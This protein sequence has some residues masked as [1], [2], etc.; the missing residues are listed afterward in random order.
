VQHGRGTVQ[1]S[2]G[3]G[4]SILFG[5]TG[6][7]LDAST[8]L[9][10]NGARWYADGQWLSEDPIGFFGGTANLYEVGEAALPAST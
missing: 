9:Q 6:R 8:G 10:N 5:F 3:A 2:T 4:Y 1:R 7:P